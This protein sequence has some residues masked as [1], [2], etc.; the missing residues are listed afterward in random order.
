ALLLVDRSSSWTRVFAAIANADPES[1]SALMVAAAE[2]I[3]DVSRFGWMSLGLAFVP[4]LAA[5]LRPAAE[6]S[7]EELMTGQV[8]PSGFRIIATGLALVVPLLWFAA[9][10]SA[11]PTAAMLRMAKL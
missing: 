1:R 5:V 3:A 4:I 8:N 7:E 11:D 2:E 9:L 10:L 6:L